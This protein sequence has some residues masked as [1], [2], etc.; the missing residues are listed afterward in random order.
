MF[1]TINFL[2]P[3]KGITRYIE[4][5]VDDN[6]IRLKTFTSIT[7]EFSLKWC[8]EQWWQN[9]YIPQGIL[10]SSVTKY[11]FYQEWFSVMVLS[12]PDGNLLGHYV[13]IDT[14]MRKVGEE[15]FLTDLFLDLWISPDG[16]LVELDWDEFEQGF[17]LRLITRWQYKK[18]IATFEQL[19]KRITSGNFIQSI[20]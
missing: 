19:K 13:D 17:R 14:P 15:Y 9:G 20:C 5:F 11:M 8:E 3:G 16:S 18:A 12:D 10:V 2:R 4:G 6:P 1:V 7:P